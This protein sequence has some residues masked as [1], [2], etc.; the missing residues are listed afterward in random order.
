[1]EV[2]EVDKTAIFSVDQAVYLNKSSNFI[3]LLL[4]S[5]HIL[6]HLVPE[7]A[8]IFIIGFSVVTR[9]SSLCIFIGS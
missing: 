7:A 5:L 3:Q 8:P 2:A 9:K 4:L 1:M 6:C